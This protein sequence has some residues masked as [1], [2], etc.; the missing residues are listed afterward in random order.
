MSDTVHVMSELS[1]I[2]CPRNYRLVTQK[3][4]VHLM[5]HK[6]SVFE[7]E[8]F[9]HNE[10]F[11]QCN[12]ILLTHTHTHSEL[13]IFSAVSCCRLPECMGLILP[14]GKRLQVNIKPFTGNQVTLRA[15]GE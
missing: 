14:L 9:P 11:G 5:L 6:Q 3:Q 8:D 4:L 2:S 13:K 15:R 12:I 10:T 7:I 1:N